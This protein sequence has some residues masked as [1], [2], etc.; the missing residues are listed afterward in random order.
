MPRASSSR[1]VCKVPRDALSLSLVGVVVV[2]RVRSDSDPWNLQVTPE[3]DFLEG[4]HSRKRTSQGP[5]V[6]SSRQDAGRAKWMRPLL[7]VMMMGDLLRRRRR[8]RRYVTRRCRALE[9]GEGSVAGT[10]LLV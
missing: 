5:V 8:G 1:G 2:S 4:I 6:L 9:S 7:A 10:C 3:A